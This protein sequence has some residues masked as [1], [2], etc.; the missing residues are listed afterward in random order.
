MSRYLMMFGYMSFLLIALLCMIGCSITIKPL[1]QKNPENISDVKNSENVSKVP[2]NGIAIIDFTDSDGNVTVMGKYVADS[3]FKS[4]S[5]S[6]VENLEA[7][8]K[9][10]FLKEQLFPEST[11]ESD[12]LNRNTR[13]TL[14]DRKYLNDLLE[15]YEITGSDLN[16][17]PE[18]VKKLRQIP[19][20]KYLVTGTID[21]NKKCFVKLQDIDATEIGSLII[22]IGNP[23][24]EPLIFERVLFVGYPHNK[25]ATGQFHLQLPWP[26]PKASASAVVK[27]PL[28]S[29]PQST[30]LK[31][32]AK[33]LEDAFNLAG[34]SDRTYYQIPK[35]FALVSRIEQFDLDGTPKKIPDD[36]WAVNV[37][38]LNIITLKD[39]FKSLF[40]A[41][42]GHY[43]IIVF[44]VTSQP[45]EQAPKEVGQDEAMNWSSFGSPILPL[46]IGR[47]KYTGDYYCMAVIYEFEQTTQDH[48]PVFKY[49]SSLP[50]MEHLKK[51]NL[52]SALKG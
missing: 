8:I 26:L 29:S 40:Y 27:I 48:D 23:D 31:D 19:E 46:D 47:I 10:R 2:K 42:E 25:E 44:I 6:G 20:I 50:G 33:R 21:R 5:L 18:I 1:S 51:A 41:Q 11:N 49:P 28:K 30:L 9:A 43:R 38:P 39:Y 52:W 3:F 7:L 34:Y 13:L 22:D 32:I 12:H 15:K 45:L 14:I 4:L 24:G 17:N 16:K 37:N 35:G 36:R